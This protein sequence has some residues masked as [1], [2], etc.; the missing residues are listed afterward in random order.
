MVTEIIPTKFPEQDVKAM[1]ALI[2]KGVFISRSDLIRDAAR[3]KIREVKAPNE[4]EKAVKV[5]A[6]KGDFSSLEGRTLASLFLNPEKQGFNP[7]EKKTIAKLLRHPFK[8]LK[9]LRTRVELTDNGQ[10]IAR[11]YLKGLAFAQTLA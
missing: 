6:A 11:G 8:I 4:F 9:K 2:K 1:D 3:E 10:K 7:A 5:M